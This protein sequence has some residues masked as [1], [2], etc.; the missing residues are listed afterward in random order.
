[1]LVYLRK[2][3]LQSVKCG[4][5]RAVEYEEHALSS[6]VVGCGDCLEPFLARSVPKL[7][8]NAFAF[9]LH[10]FDLEIDTYGWQMLLWKP[11][12]G[13]AHQQ[14]RLADRRVPDQNEFNQSVEILAP[15]HF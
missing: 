8:F 3:I 7:Q 12:L 4:S 10:D 5:I 11:V 1:M 15:R 13:E 9:R 2:P 14:T 6:F